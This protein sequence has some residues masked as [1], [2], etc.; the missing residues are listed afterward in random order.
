MSLSKL[1]ELVMDREAWRPA[2][3]GVAKS[4]TQ[5]SDWTEV[6]VSLCFVAWGDVCPGASIAAKGPGPRSQPV[7]RLENW[8]IRW[9]HKGGLGCSGAFLLVFR[10][11][12]VS[13]LLPSN[14]ALEWPFYSFGQ[15]QSSWPPKEGVVL[16][17]LSVLG[18]ISVPSL[19][20]S[21]SR[22]SL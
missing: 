3:H 7:S 2:I 10:V 15:T 6:I 4:L 21:F 9:E 13:L 11:V 22:H 5:L 19:S 14:T 12:F 1:W 18:L 8:V 17:L 20:W 16:L